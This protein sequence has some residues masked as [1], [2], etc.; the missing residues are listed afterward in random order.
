MQEVFKTY[1]HYAYYATRDT[2]AE[3]AGGVKRGG[4]VE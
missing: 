1:L 2:E 3:P 4:G